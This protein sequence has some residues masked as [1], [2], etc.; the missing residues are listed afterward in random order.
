MNNEKIISDLYDIMTN[1]CDDI[2]LY[3][4]R[5]MR[6]CNDCRAKAIFNAGYL[7]CKDKVVL[8]GE[9]YKFLRTAEK[10]FASEGEVKASELLKSFRAIDKQARK[11]AV[12][13][14]CEFLVEQ[15]REQEYMGV[16]YKQGTFTNMNIRILCKKFM[17]KDKMYK[18]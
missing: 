6:N 11:E 8:T 10:L 12:L 14:F 5:K 16:K 9:E 13:D 7:N 2:S 17:K 15:M 18:V 3:E 1:C 4:C